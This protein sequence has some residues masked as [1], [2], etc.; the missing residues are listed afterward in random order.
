MLNMSFV[1]TVF[2]QI[3]KSVNIHDLWQRETHFKGSVY[4][5]ATSLYYVFDYFLIL[6]GI[7]WKSSGEDL[8]NE[9]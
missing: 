3:L 9:K 7:R 1:S 6:K 8:Y 5:L 4:L 2:H